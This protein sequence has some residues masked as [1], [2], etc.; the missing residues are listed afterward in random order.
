MLPYV[1][2]GMDVSFSGIL[3]HLEEQVG[4]TFLEQGVCKFKVTVIC[5]P[6][7]TVSQKTRHY[8]FNYNLNKNCLITVI[9]GALISRQKV[10]SVFFLRASVLPWETFEP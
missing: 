5:L 2:K 9:F 8:I 1:V 3:S 10:V 6:I 4:S 7:Y